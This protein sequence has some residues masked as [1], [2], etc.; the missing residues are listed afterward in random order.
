MA[1]IA[2]MTDFGLNDG[3]V[4]IM[5]G[6]IWRIAPQAQI[7]DIS[8]GIGP[9]DVRAGAIMLWRALR[10]FPDGAI[11]VAVVDPGV[12]T[13]RRPIAAAVGPYYF[14]GPDNG[15]ITP[16]LEAAAENGWAVSVV[17]LDRPA[18]W[19]GDVSHIFHGRDI[20][21]P[22]AAHL[23]R[24]VAL[25][26][27]GTAITDPVRLAL[28]RPAR[29]AQGWRGEVIQVD[30]FGNLLTNILRPHLDALGDAPLRVRLAGQE[31]AGLARTFGDRPEGSLIALYGTDH[32]LIISI[33]N[34]NAAASLP[35]GVG[36]GVEVVVNPT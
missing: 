10:F 27:L 12:G 34:G 26:E 7:A 23:A 20:F 32:D 2:L 19:L 15:L 17:H 8:H 30:H 21:A 13:E 9:Q 28:P 35:A 5:K 22:S 29:T 6:V 11:F 1:V 36:D 24:G 4:G 33:V 18:Y 25:A 16:L 3:A 14:V 31:I